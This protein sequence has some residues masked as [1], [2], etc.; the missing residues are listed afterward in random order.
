[1][2]VSSPMLPETTMNGTSGASARNTASA[3]RRREVVCVVVGQ[4]DVQTAIDR[5]REA[6]FVV[7]NGR[8]DVKRRSQ[9]TEDELSVIRV[10]FQEEDTQ[11]HRGHVVGDLCRTVASSPPHCQ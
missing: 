4:H 3:R 7:D 11:R 8:I 5:R 10:V 9:L 6:A 1:M 2:A